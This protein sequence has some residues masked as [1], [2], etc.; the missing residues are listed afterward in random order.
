MLHDVAQCNSLFTT[1][2][3][4]RKDGVIPFPRNLLYQKYSVLLKKEHVCYFWLKLPS[5]RDKI[6][7]L[8]TYIWLFEIL[9]YI[10]MYIQFRCFFFSEIDISLWNVNLSLEDNIETKFKECSDFLGKKDLTK[11]ILKNWLFFPDL[12][13]ILKI[14][15]GLFKWHGL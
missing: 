3:K 11:N 14:I 13:G 8:P 10:Y 6:F 9:I 4:V 12:V 1:T 2:G 5:A 15:S 7:I